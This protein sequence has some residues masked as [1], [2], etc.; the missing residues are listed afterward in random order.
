MSGPMLAISMKTGVEYLIISEIVVEL[1]KHQFLQNLTK[2]REYCHWSVV[3]TFKQG[4]LL[5]YRDYLWELPAGGELALH[6]WQSNYVMEWGCY[7]IRGDLNAEVVKFIHCCTFGILK[8]F[9]QFFLSEW[10]WNAGE[11][12]CKSSPSWYWNKLKNLVQ[13]LL[14][15]LLFSEFSQ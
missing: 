14:N 5:V 8:I 10:H 7:D 1:L 12:V 15:L 11:K 13:L 3:L 4:T 6:Y 2:W 9:Q